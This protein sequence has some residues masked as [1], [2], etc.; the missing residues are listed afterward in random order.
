MGEDITHLPT[1]KTMSCTLPQSPI[2]FCIL[3]VYLCSACRPKPGGLNC[4]FM[5][6]LTETVENY[7][8]AIFRFSRTE[9]SVST[10]VIAQH[11]GTSAAS[12]TDM[13]KKLCDEKL[14]EY[15]PYKGATLTPEGQQVALQIIRKHRLWEVFLVEKLQFSWDNVH[16]VAE[17]LEHIDSPELIR[18]L[19]EFLGYPKFDPHGDPIP[20]EDGAIEFR[21]TLLLTELLPGARGVLVRVRRSDADF[22]QYLDR[23][24]LPL[25]AHIAL[26]ERLPYD[27]SLVLE[28]GT[29]QVVLGGSI[30]ENLFL[31]PE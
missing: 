16:D 18:R 26:V 22:L 5:K 27:D 1:V 12:V 20:D 23:L 19:D 3:Y 4:F 14:V 30:A 21:N 25:G 28:V 7:L 10:N 31:L 29:R 6:R 13:L 2:P 11:L 17:Q 15:T 24:G 8:K 9:Q